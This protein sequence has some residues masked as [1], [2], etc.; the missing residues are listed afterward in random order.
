VTAATNVLAR[1]GFGGATLGRIADEAGLDKRNILYY[2]DT[3]EALLVR[4]V[5]AVGER[6]A[7]HIEAA[8]GEVETP[9]QLADALVD[10]MWSG[11]TSAPEFARAYFALV[12]GGA[13]SPEVEEALRALKDAYEQLIARQLQAVAH[14]RWRLRDDLA[15]MVTLTL[16]VFRGLLLEWTETGDT[17]ASAAGL[18]RLKR[19]IAAEYVLVDD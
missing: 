12:G 9:V 13:G 17:A 18:R 8:V 4:V 16:A 7:E 14:T 19:A 10:A 3:R 15:G 11:I 5:Q 1:D 6:V 2:Y